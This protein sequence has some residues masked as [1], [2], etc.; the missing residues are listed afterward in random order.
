MNREDA[1]NYLENSMAFDKDDSSRYHNEVLEFT[2]KELKQETNVGHWIKNERTFWTC[3][4]C[5]F[6]NHYNRKKYNY[7]PDC[8]AKMEY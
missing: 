6:V 1:I 2:I 4:K 8:G 3:D 7:C 5:G